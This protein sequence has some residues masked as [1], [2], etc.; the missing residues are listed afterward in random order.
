MLVF[1]F[2]LM[3]INILCKKHKIVNLDDKLRIKNEIRS[4]NVVFEK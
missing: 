3:I 4:I 2:N 1:M